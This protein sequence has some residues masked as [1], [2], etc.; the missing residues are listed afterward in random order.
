L[1]TI[2]FSSK[3]SDRDSDSLSNSVE[4]WVDYSETKTEKPC[5]IISFKRQTTKPT[6]KKFSDSDLIKPIKKKKL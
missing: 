2:H 3:K 6:I 1:N 4:D 5:D